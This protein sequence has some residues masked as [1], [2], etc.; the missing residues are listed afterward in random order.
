ML[1][2]THSPICSFCLGQALARVAES[3]GKARGLDTAGDRPKPTDRCYFCDRQ[4]VSCRLIAY[5]HPASICGDCLV[6]ITTLLANEEV[7]SLA[8][9]N[10]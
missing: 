2:G 3:H 10:F 4:V 6:H 7:E 5:Q 1:L 8:I 9:V